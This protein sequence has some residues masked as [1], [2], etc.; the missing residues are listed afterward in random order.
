MSTHSCQVFS[1]A[2]TNQF[3]GRRTLEDPCW[4]WENA[5]ER[6]PGRLL[7]F[8]PPSW[9]HLLLQTNNTAGQSP[10]PW[11]LWPHALY[12]SHT[13]KASNTKDAI[14]QG[15]STGQGSQLPVFRSEG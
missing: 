5:D 6:P 12:D 8:Q 11:S 1:E 10:T 4:C 9:S 15:R 7:S 3:R 13:A 2:I 14:L